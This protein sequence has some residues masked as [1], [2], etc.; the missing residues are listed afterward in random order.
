[1]LFY[2]AADKTMEARYEDD[3]DDDDNDDDND[4]EDDDYNDDEDGQ[5][6]EYRE[7]GAGRHIS[8]DHPLSAAQTGL[9]HFSLGKSSSTLS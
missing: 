6:R 1:M 5:D 9:L 4:D 2:A 3:D 8:W 7:T